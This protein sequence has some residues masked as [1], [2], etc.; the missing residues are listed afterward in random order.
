VLIGVS[1]PAIGADL[2]TPLRDRIPGVELHAQVLENMSDDAFLSRPPWT[3]AAEAGA[4]LVA[5][6]LLLWA[7]PRWVVRYSALLGIACAAALFAISYAEFGQDRLLVDPATPSV[8]LL[9][10]FATLLALTLADATRNRKALQRVVQLQ[11]EEAARVAGELQ[12]ARRI[13]TDTLPRPDSIADDRIELAASMEPAQEVGGD[14]YDFYMLDDRR[15]FFMLGDVAG[16]GLPASIFMAVSKALC[17]STMLR[18]REIDLGAF[19]SA[20]NVEVTRENPAALFVTVFA[21][22]LDLQTGDLEY[23]NAGHEPAWLVRAGR[24]GAVRLADGGGPPL[25]VVDDFAYRS[26]SVALAPGDMLCAVTDGVTEAGDRART[27]YGAARVDRVLAG[28]ATPRDVVATLRADVAAFA[29]GAV[30]EDDMTVLALR[31]RG[32]SQ[33]D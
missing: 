33:A 3:P 6:A 13:Q 2:C 9:V 27:L 25:C 32:P 24:V 5:G 14:L 4:L 17:K 23:A 1:A 10:L 11:R 28:A 18:A 31:W 15:F 16:H 7:T 21:G 22:V 30:A 26:A 19:L 20:A 8:A 29:S 12:A